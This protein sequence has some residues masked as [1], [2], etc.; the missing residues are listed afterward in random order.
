[1]APYISS[2]TVKALNPKLIGKDMVL[3]EL[4]KVSIFFSC[5]GKYCNAIL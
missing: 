2:V 4:N 3:D 1:M 5:L